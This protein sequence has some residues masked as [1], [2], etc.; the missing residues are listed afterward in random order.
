MLMG[1]LNSTGGKEIHYFFSKEKT[2]IYYEKEIQYVRFLQKRRKANTKSNF[3]TR[4]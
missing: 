4:V 3:E 1:K 2:E